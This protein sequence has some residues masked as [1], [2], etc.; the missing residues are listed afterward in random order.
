M[1]GLNYPWFAA[2]E[3]I[4]L[5]KEAGKAFSGGTM[6]SH[7]S[8]QDTSTPYYTRESLYGGEDSLQ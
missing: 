3:A 1:P 2:V 4:L 7:W 8:H 5:L 6:R